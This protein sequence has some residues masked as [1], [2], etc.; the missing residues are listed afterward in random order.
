MG[1]LENQGNLLGAEK[2]I[3]KLNPL[4]VSSA[5]SNPGLVGG[6]AGI[7]PTTSNVLH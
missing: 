1:K 6:K 3:V 5:K 7:L 4:M 2:R